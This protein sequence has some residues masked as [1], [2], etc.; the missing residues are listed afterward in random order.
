[1]SRYNLNRMDA[2]SRGEDIRT[3]E[4]RAV[5]YVRVSTDSSAQQ[6]SFQNQ[7]ETYRE[8][9]QCNP[10]W[11]YAGTYSDDAVSGTK[12]RLRPG[13]RQMIDDAQKGR[14]DLIVV[15]DISRFARNL[16][17]CLMYVDILKG[18]GVM[19]WFYNDHINSFS[20]NDEIKLR[21]MALG[22]EM[23]ARS[24]RG[25]TQI[26]F[27][28]GIEHGRVYG[29]SKILGY[30]KHQCSLVIDPYEADIVRLIF[31]L[32]V[33]NRQGLRA[34]EKELACRGM[35]R[36]D[37]SPIRS[38]TIGTVLKNPKYKGFY[39]GRKSRKIDVGERYV[40]QA[41]PPSEWQ[42]YP[43][44]HIP[45]IV[46]PELW[47]EAAKIRRERSLH[48]AHGT[49]SPLNGGSYAFSGKIESET[50]PGVHYHHSLYRYKHIT[51]EIWQCRR[52]A[53]SSVQ[54]GPA[55][56]NDEL[57]TCLLSLFLNAA[58][59]LSFLSDAL[60]SLYSAEPAP[61][62]ETSHRTLLLRD[63]QTIRTR[64]AR[65]LDLYQEGSI[66]K[67]DFLLQHQKNNQRLTALTAAMDAQP[68]CSASS[69]FSLTRRQLTEALQAALDR[70]TL[71]RT[72]VDRLIQ[73]IL[74]CQ[75]ST[76]KQLKLSLTLKGN[77]TPLQLS[78][79]R[80]SQSGELCNRPTS[81]PV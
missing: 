23:E 25:R 65:L 61:S 34:I 43:D 10:C 33:H 12:V 16:K 35:T 36:R 3:M 7:I 59:G 73:K 44:P 67:A 58:G 68:D 54:A 66:T 75:S 72:T 69:A 20:C 27:E 53:N 76:R 6:N 74:V 45:A 5:D 8:L 78:I 51:R 52:P 24:I 63:L 47:D 56:Y 37:H 11:H 17:E 50:L 80:T 32:Y 1:M 49:T 42:L 77:N 4:L 81:T 18:C 60:Y 13:F 26:V 79:L 41:L 19:V 39:C 40:R 28:Q 38:T 31:D 2:V 71:S 64:S 14:F 70:L 46:S 30:T 55:V 15:K 48:S 21:F 22:A 9:I 57:N 29:N 62:A